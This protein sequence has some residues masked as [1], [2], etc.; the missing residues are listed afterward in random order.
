MKISFLFNDQVL[1]KQNFFITK[2]KGF[3]AL[4][5]M[6]IPGKCTLA[7]VTSKS[8]KLYLSEFELIY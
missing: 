4:E 7:I 2:K 3:G 6:F 5:N 1:F 8:T